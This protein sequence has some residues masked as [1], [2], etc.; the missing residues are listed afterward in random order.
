MAIQVRRGIEAD[1]TTITPASGEPIWV[2]DSK[3]LLIG[4]GS[5]AGAIAV[6][7]NLFTASG[8]PSTLYLNGDYYINTATGFLYQQQAGAWVYIMTLG[9]SGGTSNSDYNNIFLLM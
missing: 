3:R 1:R 4:D 5:T 2:T 6:S 9:G 7:T 8:V